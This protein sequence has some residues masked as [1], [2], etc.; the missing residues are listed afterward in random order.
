[1]RNVSK[2]VAVSILDSSLSVLLAVT[3]LEYEDKNW[4]SGSE[5]SR[6]EAKMELLE[7]MKRQLDTIKK[8]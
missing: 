8:S 7:Y 1:V 5:K 3:T 6:T 2:E 4:L